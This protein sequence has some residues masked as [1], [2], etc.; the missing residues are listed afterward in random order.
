MEHPTVGNPTLSRQVVHEN[1][2]KSPP[3]TCTSEPKHRVTNITPGNIN[4]RMLHNTT[5][6]KK[7]VGLV[8]QW[9]T[10]SVPIYKKQITNLSR[11]IKMVKLFIFN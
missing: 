3:L 2:E 9:N 1:L 5:W 6:A 7:N 11:P 10:T 8:Y 4:D